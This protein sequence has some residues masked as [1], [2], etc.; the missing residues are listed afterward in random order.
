MRS[1][2]A[3][4]DIQAAAAARN[5]VLLGV[6][7]DLARNYLQLRGLQLRLA[8]LREN[9]ASAT[10]SRDLEQ[11]R[12]ERGITNEL[13]LQLAIRELSSLQSQLP[14][15]QVRCRPPST[16]SPCCAPDSIPRILPP[17]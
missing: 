3:R 13:D 15:I 8:I 17:S 7:G 16:G 2:P 14:P 6:V 1:R 4:Y 11:I 10:Q 9:I 5:A 12:F